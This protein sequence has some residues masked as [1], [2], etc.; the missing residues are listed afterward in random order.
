[1]EAKKRRT[2]VLGAGLNVVTCRSIGICIFLYI[3]LKINAW[4]LILRTDTR[5]KVCTF[6]AVEMFTL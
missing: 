4:S 6:Y 1:M 2:W 5:N 3:L